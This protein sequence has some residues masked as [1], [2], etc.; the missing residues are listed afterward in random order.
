MNQLH[1]DIRLTDELERQLMQAAVEDQMRIKPGKAL[2]NLFVK[3]GGK[4]T[5]ATPAKRHNGGT[6][7][8][9]A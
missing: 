8:S 6:V 5:K 3:L 2:K 7:G 1:S 4:A 9:A